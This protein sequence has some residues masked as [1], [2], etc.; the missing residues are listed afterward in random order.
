MAGL[1]PSQSSSRCCYYDGDDLDEYVT[2]VIPSKQTLPLKILSLSSKLALARAVR[3]S[4]SSP[5]TRTPLTQS[6]RGRQNG[7]LQL[8]DWCA[9]NGGETSDLVL[10]LAHF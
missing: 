6:R 3:A 8:I 4:L 1:M 5:H 2:T 7:L 10:S 9:E